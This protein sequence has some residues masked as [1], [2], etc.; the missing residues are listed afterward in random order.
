MHSLL[1]SKKKALSIQLF[2]MSDSLSVRLVELLRKHPSG[3]SNKDLQDEFGDE[4]AALLPVMQSML[5][6]GRLEA[7]KKGDKPLYRMTTEKDLAD[8]NKLRG[9]EDYEVLVFQEIKKAGNTGVWTRDLKYKTGLQQNKTKFSKILKNLERK[10]LIK[11]C[12]TIAAKNKKIYMLF[13]LEPARELRGGAWY[14]DNEFD[15]A[16]ISTV[17]NFLLKWLNRAMP[18]QVVSMLEDKGPKITELYESGKLT[19]EDALTAVSSIDIIKTDVELAP[20][21]LAQILDLLCYDGTVYKVDEN[22]KDTFGYEDEEGGMAKFVYRP[23]PTRTHFNSFTDTP[24]GLCPV[25]DQCT[26]EGTISPAKCV[27]LKQWLSAR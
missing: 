24:C 7:L 1:I 6:E 23:M 20:D 8:Y 10:R 2:L 17:S 11:S 19:A 4:F 27:Y 16:M 14:T 3:A 15:Q 18:A 26:P 13:D 25:F 21:D 22:K 5:N 12:R 9:L